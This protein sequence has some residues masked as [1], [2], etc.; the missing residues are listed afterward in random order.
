MGRPPGIVVGPGKVLGAFFG[1]NFFSPDF[2][3]FKIFFFKL[4]SVSHGWSK[5]FGNL[6]YYRVDMTLRFDEKKILNFPNFR[7]FSLVDSF[8]LFDAIWCLGHQFNQ[9]LS[10]PSESSDIISTFDRGLV[11]YF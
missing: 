9:I 6:I 2:E 7:K 4:L 1:E 10:V 11:L 3:I 5:F 8:S